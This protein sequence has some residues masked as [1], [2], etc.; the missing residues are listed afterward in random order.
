MSESQKYQIKPRELYQEGK[1]PSTALQC[2]RCGG[3]FPP[4]KFQRELKLSK[5]GK[6]GYIRRNFCILCPGN[7]PRPTNSYQSRTSY[8]EM[9]SRV[10]SLEREVREQDADLTAFANAVKTLTA[11]IESL[12]AS[13]DRSMQEELGTRTRRSRFEDQDASVHTFDS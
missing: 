7:D 5:K 10:E 9:K 13:R 2:N 11:R 1:E 8:N 6:T 3:F 12:E 4:C